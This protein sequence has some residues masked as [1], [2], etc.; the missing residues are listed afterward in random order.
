[1]RGYQ[2]WLINRHTAGQGFAARD[3]VVGPGGTVFETVCL[4][5]G[6]TC[7]A[8]TGN[9]LFLWSKVCVEK[10]CLF[11]DLPSSGILRSICWL[12]T[13]VSEQFISSVGEGEA[14]RCSPAVTLK[15]Q[16][17]GCPETSVNKYQHTLRNISE[18]RRSYVDG[19]VSR[20]FLIVSAV[21]PLMG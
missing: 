3:M 15:M 12:F 20:N 6:L 2:T 21:I 8:V 9:I 7:L 1:V 18:E 19:G 13:D 16:P 17:I 14:V 4:V 10:Y 11:W 5:L